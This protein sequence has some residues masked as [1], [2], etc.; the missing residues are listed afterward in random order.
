M[1][2]IDHLRLQ[3]PAAYAR[4]AEAIARA[5]ASAL[6]ER[7]PARERAHA[8]LAL[9]PL[10]LPAGLPPARVAHLIAGAVHTALERP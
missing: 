3:L 1:L 2:S 7:P 9:A 10:R 4:E 8:H 6:A 5:L